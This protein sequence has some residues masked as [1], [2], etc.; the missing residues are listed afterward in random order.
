MAEHGHNQWEA[1]KRSDAKCW[2]IR[3]DLGFSLLTMDEDGWRARR[4]A[5]TLNLGEAEMDA[6]L[7][8]GRERK[9]EPIDG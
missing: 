7:R 2:T 3:D 8:P 1:V 4:I 5:E 9:T 6:R